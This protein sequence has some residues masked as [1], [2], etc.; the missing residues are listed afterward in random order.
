MI[1]TLVFAA[2]VLLLF[3]LPLGVAFGPG[4]WA[5]LR[6]AAAAVRAWRADRQAWRAGD[7]LHEW[8]AGMAREMA[9]E[10]A[11]ALHFASRRDQLLL[12]RRLRARGYGPVLAGRVRR[13]P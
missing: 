4:D 5:A 13:L 10:R 7:G 1:E 9:G 2:F 11:W 6:R 12:N 3:A 8:V